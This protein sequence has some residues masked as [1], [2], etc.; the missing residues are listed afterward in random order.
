MTMESIPAAGWAAITAAAGSVVAWLTTRGKTDADVA[1]VL[2]ETSIEWIRELR[3]EVERA[4]KKAEQADRR[5]ARAEEA[6]RLCQ[7][8]MD[9]LE[10]YLREMGLNPPR[11]GD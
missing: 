1:S 3:A 4:T 8:R 7:R 6:E 10:D 11:T 2:S 5:A 9:R